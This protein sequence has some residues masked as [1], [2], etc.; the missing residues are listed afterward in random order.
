MPEGTNES[1]KGGEG[2]NAGG[3]TPPEPKVDPKANAGAAGEGKK[4]DEGKPAKK[5]EVETKG[6]EGTPTKKEPKQIGEDDELP[7]DSEL[8]SMSKQALTKRLDRHTKKELRERFGT[9]DYAKIKADLDELAGFRAKREEER[10]A[11]LTKEQKLQEERDAEKRR[12]DEAEAKLARERDSQVFAEYDATAKEVFTDKVAPKHVKRAMR[13]LK[14]HILSLDDAEAPT[15]PK[16][17]KKVF[18]KWMKDWL[19]ENPEFAKPAAEEPKKIKLSTGADPNAKREKGDPN[20][21]HKT[22]KPGAVN[23]MSKAEYAQYKRERGLA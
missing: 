5:P 20:L 9:D 15:E 3:E 17:A 19:E 11:S 10:K 7:E 13:E 1:G 16:K 12:A 18:E 2:T 22:P 14:E 21:A 6:N 23:S 8:V 4:P